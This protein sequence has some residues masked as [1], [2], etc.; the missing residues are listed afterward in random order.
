MHNPPDD[1]NSFWR[2][3]RDTYGKVRQTVRGRSSLS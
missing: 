1:R 3:H 2:Y